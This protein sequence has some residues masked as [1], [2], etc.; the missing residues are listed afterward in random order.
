MGVMKHL[1]VLWLTVSAPALAGGTLQEARQALLRGNYAE[2]RET[3]ERERAALKS[4]LADAM[5]ATLV[6]DGAPR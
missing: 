4:R 6:R 5:S 3:Y 2:A 1:W